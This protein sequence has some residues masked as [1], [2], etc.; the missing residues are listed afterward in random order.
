MLE[1]YLECYHCAIAH[2]GFSAAIDVR[3]E[4]YDLVAHGWVAS[5]VGEVRQSALEG[6]SAVKIY[7]ARGEIAQSQYHLLWPNLTININ[8][9]FP[10]LSLDVWMP[11]GPNGAKGFTEQY[12]A[13][14]V[15]EEFASALIAFNI[16]VGKEDDDLTDSV[17]RGLLAGIPARGRFL[18]NSEHL[19]VH[20]QKL[21]VNALGGGAAALRAEAPVATASAARSIAVTPDGSQPSEDSPNAYIALEVD[22]VVPES[23]VISSFY[24]RRVDGK[25]LKPWE[26]GQFLPIRVVIP[27]HAKPVLRT[28]TLSMAANPDHYRLSIR[29]GEGNALVS[30][31]LH[32]NARPGFRLEAMT[33]RGKFVLDRS[34]ERPVVLVSGGVGVTPM[35]AMATDIVE[36][37]GAHR[38]VPPG[39]FRARHAERPHPCLRR[40]CQGAA[41]QASRLLDACRL[42]PA[43]RERPAGQQP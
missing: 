12:F 2:P 10:N 28:Y 7:E 37:G 27:G 43:G 13:P 42:Q 24:L 40:S 9:G 31:F 3:P 11:N 39:L 5:Q 22:K 1:N 15:T 32:A 26:P 33:P 29:R 35:I 8:P 30:S 38:Q 19:V 21:V 41:G 18:T 6:K 17:Q 16:E 4:N 23:E 36:E 20:F 14:G 25:P 34:S